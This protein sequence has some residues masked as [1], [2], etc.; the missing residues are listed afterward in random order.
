[1]RLCKTVCAAAVVAGV[2]AATETPLRAGVV[3]SDNFEDAA[4]NALPNAP[5]VG[6]YPTDTATDPESIVVAAGGSR[7]ASPATGSNLLYIFGKQRNYG[8]FDASGAGTVRYELDAR[9]ESATTAFSIGMTGDTGTASLDLLP[10]TLWLQFLSSGEIQA[11]DSTNGGWQTISGISQTPGAWQ[12][13]A[14]EYELGATSYTVTAGANTVTNGRFNGTTSAS[15]M[16]HV[17]ANGGTNSTAA[18]IDNV[19][20]TFAPV[21]EPGSL[22]LLAGGAGLLLARRRRFQEP[23]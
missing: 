22:A 1:M 9:L 16:N 21:P 8:L 10:T 3:F 13:Y 15:Q 18:Y 6:A 2:L 11:Y 17:F 19:V 23:A 4:A 20:V 5:Q 7:P 14:I 12:H